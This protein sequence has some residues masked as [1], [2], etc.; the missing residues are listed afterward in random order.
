[1]IGALG[2]APGNIFITVSTM[3]FNYS[4][5]LKVCE[6]TESSRGAVVM[7]WGRVVVDTRPRWR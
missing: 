2:A 1:M 6:S 5:V 4:W 7:M 3:E